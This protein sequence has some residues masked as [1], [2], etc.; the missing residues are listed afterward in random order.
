MK[1]SIIGSGSFGTFVRRL[2]PS[3]CD[4]AVYSRQPDQSTA[5]V[6][7][8]LAADIIILA[9][10]LSAYDEFLS[11]HADKIAAHSLVI[12]VCS[13]KVV[14]RKKLHQYLPHHENILMTHPLFGPESAATST[15][16]FNLI[17]TE[18]F[19]ALADKCIDYCQDVLG[20][21]VT[22]MTADT[23]DQEM[24]QVH[25]LTFFVGRSLRN[26]NLPAVDFMTPSYQTVLD[27]IALDKTHSEELFQTI[28]HGNPYAKAARQRFIDAAIA[29]NDAII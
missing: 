23:H 19:G 16:G 14:P 13:V 1:C 9:I 7:D 18:K 27:Y 25:A 11:E 28:E 15:N 3:S 12:D 21:I 2:I 8:A 17:V 4:V 24:A 26:M 5:T 10:P 20:L 29:T 6:D 22:T